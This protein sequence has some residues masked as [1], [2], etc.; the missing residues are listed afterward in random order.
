MHADRGISGIGLPIR[1]DCRQQET[2]RVLIDFRFPCAATAAELCFGSLG[3]DT[4]GSVRIPA[5]YCGIVGRQPA[6]QD[7]LPVAIGRNPESCRSSVSVIAPGAERRPIPTGCRTTGFQPTNAECG[8]SCGTPVR[9]ITALS[10]FHISMGRNERI[11]SA[12]R[13]PDLPGRDQFRACGRQAGSN[14]VLP[15]FP[16]SKCSNP[17][18]ISRIGLEEDPRETSLARIDPARVDS[19]CCYLLLRCP[20]GPCVPDGFWPSF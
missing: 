9:A 15:V 7:A 1:L 20:V 6:R 4:A 19:F 3:T 17:A 18:T 8:A 14:S 10:R 11:S 13:D 5:A 12:R 2:R 16:L